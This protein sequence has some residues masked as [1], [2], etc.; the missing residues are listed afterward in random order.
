MESSSKRLKLSNNQSNY[1]Q[2]NY[3]QPNY[4]Q[5]NY[6]Q[7]LLINNLLLKINNL[8]V[9]INH[10]GNLCLNLTKNIESIKNNEKLEK[11]IDNLYSKFEIIE[12]KLELLGIPKEEDKQPISS[13]MMNAYC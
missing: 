12:T 11:I 5:P 2:S 8:E 6:N 4:N 7:N 10:I 1:N 3:N 13:E 9:K